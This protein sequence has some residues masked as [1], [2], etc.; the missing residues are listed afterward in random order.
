MPVSSERINHKF[1]VNPSSRLRQDGNVGIYIYLII[2]LV[3]ARLVGK[4]PR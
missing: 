3:V 2:V 4:V 1:V